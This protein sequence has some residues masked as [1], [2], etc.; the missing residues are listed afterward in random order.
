MRDNDD[1]FSEDVLEYV[2]MVPLQLLV[3]GRAKSGKSVLARAIA[4]KYN[5]VYMSIESMV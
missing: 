1:P 5:L 3:I 4:K 2:R